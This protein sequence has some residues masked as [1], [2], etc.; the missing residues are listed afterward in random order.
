MRGGA[1]GLRRALRRASCREAALRSCAAPAEPAAVGLPQRVVFDDELLDAAVRVH[2]AAAR[3]GVSPQQA[4]RDSPYQWLAPLLAAK[5]AQK[6][7]L[8]TTWIA[9]AAF[10]TRVGMDPATVG[11]AL[12]VEVLGREVGEAEL[13]R[14]FEG[15]Q[16]RL[17]RTTRPSASGESGKPLSLPELTDD[18]CAFMLASRDKNMLA[19]EDVTHQLQ[20]LR[21]L[22]QKGTPSLEDAVR[23]LE[24]QQA[25]LQ[26][27][28]GPADESSSLFAVGESKVHF[29]LF[30][31]NPRSVAAITDELKARGWAPSPCAV[32]WVKDGELRQVDTS[33]VAIGPGHEEEDGADS[34]EA[35]DLHAPEKLSPKAG[36]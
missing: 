23:Q 20:Q 28:A 8:A 17:P 12:P 1:C 33:Q 16:K 18:I 29:A 26:R 10:A 21:E 31:A 32:A 35:L 15:L 11:K 30:M 27:A 7:T 3:A 34:L 14:V 36:A 4:A 9:A 24:R 13:Q 25:A 19:L 5:A 2:A 22:Q 6:C